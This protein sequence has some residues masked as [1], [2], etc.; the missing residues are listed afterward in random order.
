MSIRVTCPGCHKRFNVSSKFAGKEGPCPS[1]KKKIKIPAVEEEVVIHAPEDM[2]PK[3]TT[4]ES[5]VKPI[6]REETAVSGVQWTLIC[7]TIIG[8]FAASGILRL[9][10]GDP[11]TFPVLLLGLGALLIAVPTVLG[12]YTFLRD[13]ELGRFAGQSLFLRVAVCSGLYAVLWSTFPLMKYAFDGYQLGAWIVAVV[14]MIAMGAAV[15]MLSL[16]LDYLV[17]IIH[18]GLYFGCCLVARIIVGIGVLPGMSDVGVDANSTTISAIWPV[19]QNP[20]FSVLFV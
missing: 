17:S 8:F 20:L 4:G 2:G 6:T 7:V 18:Y 16:N 19:L 1:C 12:G 5:S 3:D 10:I 14:A 15:G 13:Q 9:M 11:S